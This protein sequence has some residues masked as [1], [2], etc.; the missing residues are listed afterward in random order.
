MTYPRSF[1]ALGDALDRLKEILAMTPDEHRVVH[2]ATIQRF[3]FTYELFW[4][5]LKKFLEAEGMHPKTPKETLQAA[6]R[7][8]WIDDENAWLQ[9]LSDRNVTSHIYDQEGADLIFQRI[10]HHY[11]IMQEA[12]DRLHAAGH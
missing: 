10:H 9:M 12:Y 4:K 3:E 7:L 1:P 11:K 6:Y 2:D 5:T 8:E